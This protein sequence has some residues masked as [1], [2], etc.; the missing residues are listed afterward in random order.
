[1]KK[2]ITILLLFLLTVTAASA[3]TAGNM[4]NSKTLEFLQ[5]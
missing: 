4:D 5:G 3:Q 2:N 1:M